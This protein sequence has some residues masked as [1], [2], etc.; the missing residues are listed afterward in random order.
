[1]I[2]HSAF[3]SE[4][5]GSAPL[6]KAPLV[7]VVVPVWN[8]GD[9]I[10]DL[11]E[12]LSRQTKRDV[13]LLFV[14]DGSSDDTLEQ[15]QKKE[16][17]SPFR[18]RIFSQ[19]NAGVSAARN[20]GM[21]E[22]KGEYITFLDVDDILAPN[23]FDVIFEAVTKG[24]TEGTDVQAVLFESARVSYEEAKS[25]EP[26]VGTFEK[27][28]GQELLQRLLENPTRYGV[29][30]LCMK[31]SLIEEYGISFPAGYKYYEDYDFLYRSF[32]VLDTIETF[33]GTLYQYVQRP[34]SAVNKFQP[35]RYNDLSLMEK[36]IPWFE[37]HA[38]SFVPPFKQWGVSRLYWSVLWQ[39]T[40][41]LADKPS[42]LQFAKDTNAKRQLSM[43]GGFPDK[44]VRLS[45]SLFL[46]SP[47]MFRLLARKAA[48]S[49]TMIEPVS[50]EVLR[51]Q[52]RL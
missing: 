5:W 42:F 33:S 22:A 24:A 27:K 3:P 28:S 31:R 12:S 9:Y 7:T 43:L 20:V 39:S 29:Y 18:V 37:E 49:R 2:E 40:F 16:K 51:P 6:E 46:K 14:N 13:E 48:G 21:Q 32:A 17:T 23:A 19:E 45:A 41:A 4:E 52:L 44:K 38:P 30:N 36:L 50:Y 34:G 25:V 8:G 47:A 1:M 26:G 11:F 15:L 10:D 35:E